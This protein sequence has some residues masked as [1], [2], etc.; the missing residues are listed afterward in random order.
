[1]EKISIILPTYNR[2]H[3][4]KRAINSVLNQTF[5]NW[6]LLIIDDGSTDNTKNIIND[7][8]NDNRIK[9]FYKENSG[10]PAGPRNMGINEATGEYIA[11]LDSDD[12]WLSEKLEKQLSLFNNTNFNIGFVGCNVNIIEKLNDNTLKSS[13]YKI[14]YNGN[15][16]QNILESNF[17][18]SCSNVLTKKNI[19]IQN[20]GFDTQLK[21]LDDWDM[22]IKISMSG[23]DFD[24]I[25]YPLFNYY[26]HET[27]ITKNFNSYQIFLEK[28]TILNKY[29]YFSED[30]KKLLKTGLQFLS[31]NN[32]V[33]SIE[34]IK[35]SLSIKPYNLLSLASY[36]LLS[37]GN[38]CKQF[39]KFIIKSITYVK[40]KKIF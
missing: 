16:L 4:L 14:K 38:F 24:F 34:Y 19:L 28:V 10:G 11:F 31:Y 12:E 21:Y 2:A 30:T 18:L 35:K 37:R 26:I 27:N 39:L 20:G 29:K 22:W 40:Y 1:M 6:E 9:Y 25:K 5:K 32:E 36:H 7:F 33:A 8:S 13:D 23:Y 3:L 15:I 17:I